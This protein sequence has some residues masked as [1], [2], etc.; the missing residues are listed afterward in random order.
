MTQF[1]I[2]ENKAVLASQLGIIDRNLVYTCID[3]GYRLEAVNPTKDNRKPFFKHKQHSVRLH[4]RK[5]GEECPQMAKLSNATKQQRKDYDQKSL[6]SLLAS[7]TNG[8]IELESVVSILRYHYETWSNIQAELLDV[9]MVRVLLESDREELEEEKKEL[10]EEKKELQERLDYQNLPE[11]MALNLI[12]EGLNQQEEDNKQE[13][14]RLKGLYEKI[15]KGESV[16]LERIAELDLVY[17]QKQS[18]YVR[19]RAEAHR[20]LQS[21]FEETEEEAIKIGQKNDELLKGLAD[22]EAR[23][24]KYNNG[25]LVQYVK[26]VEAAAEQQEERLRLANISTAQ[27]R[28]QLVLGEL[29]RPQLTEMISLAIQMGILPGSTILEG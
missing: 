25:S 27:L 10:E 14:A 3:C 29:T 17:R 12:R 19:R 9:E 8:T 28:H 20:H 15:K 11:R 13:H 22:T 24:E 4:I 7:A 5:H 16:M 1:A 18:E 26:K 6:G 21:L 23:V 2:L